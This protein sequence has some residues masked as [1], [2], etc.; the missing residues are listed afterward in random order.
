MIF[1]LVFNQ[2]NPVTQGADESFCRACGSYFMFEKLGM[3]TS[4]GM[5]LNVNK[6]KQSSEVIRLALISD[7]YNTLCLFLANRV[8]QRAF[9]S[10]KISLL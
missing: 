1:L 9:H 2:E 8:P 7:K 5:S 3:A 10:R 4:K 6:T